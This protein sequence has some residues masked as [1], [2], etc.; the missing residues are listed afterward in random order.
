MKTFLRIIE[1]CAAEPLRLFFPLGLLASAFGVMLW[2]ALSWGWLDYYPLEAHS[3][4]MAIGFG[5]CFI[6]GFMGTA[7][8][9]LLEDCPI[10][11]AS[12]YQG[13]AWSD[14]YCRNQIVF[15]HQV[16]SAPALAQPPP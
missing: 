8:P 3:R 13:G 7:G 1:R 5:G 2:P 15:K 16:D 10:I 11:E 6:T 14:P 9:R 4:W 12:L